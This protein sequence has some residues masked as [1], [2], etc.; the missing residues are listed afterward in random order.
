MNEDIAELVR[1]GIDRLPADATAPARLAAQARRHNRR[2][3][4]ALALTAA[5]GTAG[6]LSAALL[7]ATGSSAGP[8]APGQA[9]LT[10]YVAGRMEKA[11][12]PASLADTVWVSTV[13]AAV[14]PLP[15]GMT[16]V[17]PLTVSWSY[18]NLSR[19]EYIGK[20]GQPAVDVGDNW[21]IM[22]PGGTDL[23]TT[24]DYVRGTWSRV[25]YPIEGPGPGMIT[26]ASSGCAS[27]KTPVGYVGM[28]LPFFQ[29]TPGYVKATVACGALV[30]DGHAVVDGVDTIKLVAT[31]KSKARPMTVY[32]N[33]TTY[34]PLRVVELGQRT[35]YQW[36]QATPANIAQLGVPVPAG[37]RRTA[38]PPQSLLNDEGNTD[39]KTK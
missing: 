33:P 9:R 4:S 35:D 1:Q 22:R 36:L 21:G 2:R 14:I 8:R 15:G 6:V 3:R 30:A 10:A 13:Q 25:S 5:A 23:E 28:P 31:A 19:D 29:P 20:T 11:L 27:Q 24:V 7:V 37:F 26:P 38:R 39:Y 12:S 16:M 18:R 17:N 34:L 32:V